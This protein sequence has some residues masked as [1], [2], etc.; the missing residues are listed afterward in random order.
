MVKK[1]ALK[2]LTKILPQSSDQ[3]LIQRAVAYDSLSQAGKLKLTADGD[4]ADDK[5]ELPPAKTSEE[6]AALSAESK[7]IAAERKATVTTE[8][9]EGDAGD[10]PANKS[11]GDN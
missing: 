9:E 7:K 6:T 5:I 1:T 10:E 4:I 3:D 2:R 11:N 8:A